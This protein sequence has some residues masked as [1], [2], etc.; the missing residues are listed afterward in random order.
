[1]QENH[2]ELIQ[3]YFQSSSEF[4]NCVR[5]IAK[6]KYNNFQSS[7]EFKLC[8]V[9][10]SVILNQTFNPLLSLSRKL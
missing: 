9:N 1:L 10:C 2:P 8:S 5:E 3:L 4:K 6:I 7:S